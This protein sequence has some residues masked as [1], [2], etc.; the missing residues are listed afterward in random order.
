MGAR[1]ILGQARDVKQALPRR[2]PRLHGP[3]RLKQSKKGKSQLTPT[4]GRIALGLHSSSFNKHFAHIQGIS[5]EIRGQVAI[6]EMIVGMYDTPPAHRWTMDEFNNV[7][8]WLEHMQGIRSGANEALEMDEND[9]DDDDDEDFEVA[10]EGDEEVSTPNFVQRWK[11]RPL[12]ACRFGFLSPVLPSGRRCRVLTPSL[13]VTDS[14]T[15]NL[16]FVDCFS[17][18]NYGGDSKSLFQNRF[19]FWIVVPSRFRLRQED[20]DDSMDCALYAAIQE[21]VHKLDEQMH[22]V[23]VVVMMLSRV[24]IWDIWNNDMN[25]ELVGNP[26]VSSCPTLDR[27][28]KVEHYIKVKDPLTYCLKVLD[29]IGV[30]VSLVNLLPDTPKSGIK[31]LWLRDC[32]VCVNDEGTYKIDSFEWRKLSPVERQDEGLFIDHNVYNIVANETHA[33]SLWDKLES[34]YASKSGTNKLYLLKKILELKYKE[35]ILT[36]RVSMISVTPNGD[37]SLQ[38]EKSG[39]LN[40]EMGWKTQEERGQRERDNDDGDRVTTTTCGDLVCLH[41]YDTINLVSDENMWIID[42]CATLHVTSRKEFFTSYTPGGF[43]VLKMGND[44]VS[45]VIGVGDVHLQTNMGMQLMMVDMI[46]TLVLESG[47]SPKT[48]ALVSKSVNVMYMESSLWHRRL[49]HI[50]EKGLNCL[51]KKDVLSELKSIELEKCSHWMTGKQTRVSFKKHPPSNKKSEL[52]EL[53]HYDVCSPLK[54]KSFSGALYFVTFKE[55]HVLVER[56]SG[57]KLKH[58][59]TDN[60]AERMNMTFIE[61]VRCMLSKAKL[62]K[63]FWGDALLTTVHVINLSPTIALNS[64]V[65]DKIWFGKNVTYDHLHDERSK[66]DVKTR[67]C[68]FIGFGQD[69]FDYKLYD[70]VE[71]KVVRSCDVQFMEDQTIEDI[72]KV[73]KST[74]GGSAT[75]E[76]L[77]RFHEEELS[78]F[79]VFGPFNELERTSLLAGAS[80]ISRWSD[81]TLAG[82]STSFGS[83]EE[84]LFLAGW[85]A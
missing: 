79:S 13:H 62:P 81:R 45:K 60:G 36:F 49:G 8:A 66:L 6:S 15:Q 39:A 54:V 18:I 19:F 22:D 53:V 31:S 78:L 67:Q 51:A 3:R 5:T 27:N 65:S 32:L 56:Q 44:G 68:I 21:G 25:A 64:E 23:V 61:R 70:P 59:R 24:F 28:E 76:L 69:E 73:K 50:S 37:I 4:V 14:R 85:S 33:R 40:E 41:D 42:S 82:A 57:K 29:L 46:T 16:V 17:R 10:E 71:K 74:V 7:V 83:S 38:M 47:S 55:L 20:S 12:A 80:S 72:D 26:S 58:I 63:H 34:L 11:H 77:V 30:C 84:T 9:D 52:I 1:K 75:L 48:K 2:Q 43:G 35:G